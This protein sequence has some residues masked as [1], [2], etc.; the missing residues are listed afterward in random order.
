MSTEQSLLTG[1]P[2]ALFL[3]TGIHV[4]EKMNVTRTASRSCVYGIRGRLDEIALLLFCFEE[5]ME[6]LD[7][8]WVELQ[9]R[10]NNL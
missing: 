2:C 8:L 9:T 6:G 7:G 4:K 3:A 1:G 5:G 10:S